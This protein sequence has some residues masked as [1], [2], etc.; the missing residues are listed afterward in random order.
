MKPLTYFALVIVTTLSI[1]AL[2]QVPLVTDAVALTGISASEVF[3]GLE[4]ITLIFYTAVFALTY[5]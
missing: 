2:Y 3:G 4:A 5:R 1:V